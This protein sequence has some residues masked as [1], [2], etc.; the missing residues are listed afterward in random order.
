LSG[1]ILL[2]SFSSWSI[3]EEEGSVVQI[4]DGMVRLSTTMEDRCRLLRDK[5]A[6]V[7]YEDPMVYL[8]FAPDTIQ[9][10]YRVH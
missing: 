4:S 6:A 7:F 1:F 9:L 3:N 2:S 8:G 10:V 5:L